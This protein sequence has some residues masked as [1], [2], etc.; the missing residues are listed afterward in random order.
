MQLIDNIADLLMEVHL[1]EMAYQRKVIVNRIRAL[2]FQIASHVIKIYLYPSNT[3][4]RGWEKE[5]QAWVADL[6]HMRY[7][8]TKK[9][10][11]SDYFKLLYSEPFIG[12]DIVELVYS[13]SVKN[14]LPKIKDGVNIDH[15][16]KSFYEKLAKELS[17]KSVFVDISNLI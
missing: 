11:E 9:L 8:G 13:M 12:S 5:I 15:K 2:S 17:G 16:I 7:D 3:A 14:G 10:K 6:S 1:F 4:L